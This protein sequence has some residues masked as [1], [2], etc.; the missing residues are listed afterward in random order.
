M[1]RI[2]APDL[3]FWL[4]LI[5]VGAFSYWLAS[6][7][8]VG[9]TTHMGPGYV[10]RGLAIIIML[11]GAVMSVRALFAGGAPF[12]TVVIRPL[13]FVGASVAIF[14]LLLPIAGLALTSVA[15]VLCAG[16]AS[17]D[18][19]FRENILLAL[20]LSAFAVALFI[21]ALG[22]PLSIWPPR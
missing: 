9:S 4:F 1:T 10:P 19:K 20:G 5:A 8:A 6:D 22:L 14:A 18:V 16:A 7:L 3:A 12:P 21:L 2:N 15:V 17:H 13:I 11:F